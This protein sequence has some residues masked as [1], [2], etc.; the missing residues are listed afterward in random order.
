VVVSVVVSAI[1][2]RGE[3]EGVEGAQD[4]YTGWVSSTVHQRTSGINGDLKGKGFAFELRNCCF[5]EDLAAA[6]DDA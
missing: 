4:L 6:L 5:D 3:I 2:E 1:K